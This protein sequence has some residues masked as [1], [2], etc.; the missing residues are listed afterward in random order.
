MN[1][2]LAA[3]SLPEDHLANQILLWSEDAYSD[4]PFD[5]FQVDPG[6]IL[7]AVWML[8]EGDALRN[9]QHRTKSPRLLRGP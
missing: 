2:R 5:D 8:A 3:V 7:T 9:R 6:P 4:A 1:A